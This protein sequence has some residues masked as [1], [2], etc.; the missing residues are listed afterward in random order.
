MD[1]LVVDCRVH[2]IDLALFQLTV[3]CTVCGERESPRSIPGGFILPIII[4]VS[5]PS[6]RCQSSRM[7]FGTGLFRYESRYMMA[8]VV[9]ASRTHEF[10]DRVSKS[11]KRV[12]R[13]AA[14]SAV[15]SVI[16]W[17]SAL[18]GSWSTRRPVPTGDSRF[19]ISC[20][21]VNG[22]MVAMSI[23]VAGTLRR[24]P[25]SD[26]APMLLAAISNIASGRASGG[27]KHMEVKHR[28]RPAWEYQLRQ[29]VDEP[30]GMTYTVTLEIQSP[31][32]DGSALVDP[33]QPTTLSQEKR[34]A[35]AV[36][37]GDP[38]AGAA[39]ADYLQEIGIEPDGVA[40]ERKRCAEAVRKYVG[41]VR[42]LLTNTPYSSDGVSTALLIV[43][44]RIEGVRGW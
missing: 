24:N 17:A 13:Y 42:Q 2:R 44:E 1:G 4:A 16:A 5:I 30:D 14:T 20:F 31:M 26:N 15:P 19:W 43:A 41:E 12:A 11:G 6:N 27:V 28:T 37:M 36:L 3:T 7:N 10:A 23:T 34:L 21:D 35:I 25:M 18:F 9:A 38:G 22:G 8:R 33:C 29:V 39:L 40:G 32:W